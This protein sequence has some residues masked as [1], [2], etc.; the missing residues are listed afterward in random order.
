[1]AIFHVEGK[2]ELTIPFDEFEIP[3]VTKKFMCAMFSFHLGTI[4]ISKDDPYDANNNV[5]IS[6]Y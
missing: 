4:H 1:M 2:V 5:I 6:I 3:H